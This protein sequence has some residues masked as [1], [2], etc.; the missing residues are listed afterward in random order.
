MAYVILSINL[1]IL[2]EDEYI[3]SII[4]E[5]AED[6]D[7]ENVVFKEESTTGATTKI[8][9]LDLDPEKYYYPR[10][11]VITNKVTSEPTELQKFKGTDRTV[12][13]YQEDIPSYVNR[14]KLF[15]NF[16]LDNAPNSLLEVFSSE[17]TT[18]G[19]GKHFFSDIWIEDEEQNVYYTSFRNYE[20]LT[21]IFIDDIALPTNKFY[22]LKV[23]HT[24]T[25]NDVSDVAK[26]S[27]YIPDVPEVKIINLED[28]TGERVNIYG[29]LKLEL[30]YVENISRFEYTL[31]QILDKSISVLG[32]S[33]SFDSFVTTLP[34]DI[35]PDPNGTYL[36]GVRAVKTDGYVTPYKYYKFSTYSDEDYTLE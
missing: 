12:V 21:R 19:N 16:P 18:T 6:E 24:S 11:T 4:W 23:V 30:E 33:G 35:F 13:S 27:F 9:A 28:T 25:S 31:Y 20:Q 26:L 17:M 29:G 14:P 22:S 7:Y 3:K 8:I 36:L 5:I 34:E 2:E 10:A 1:P 15:S 32:V